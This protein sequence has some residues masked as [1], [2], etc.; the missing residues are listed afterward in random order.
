MIYLDLYLDLCGS[1]LIG[2]ACHSSC[3][4][5]ETNRENRHWGDDLID[6]P[7]KHADCWFQSWLSGLQTPRFLRWFHVGYIYLSNKVASFGFIEK[8]DG[9]PKGQFW[10]A[11][12]RRPCLLG[13]K[14]NTCDR[15]EPTCHLRANW[16][17]SGHFSANNSHCIDKMIVTMAL[18][19][20]LRQFNLLRSTPVMSESKPAPCSPRTAYP[21]IQHGLENPP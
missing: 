8:M 15:G 6:F 4:T 13:S 3:L 20:R 9:I 19:L 18:L 1:I 16:G 10:Y 7:L 11:L 12:C 17:P 5:L 21:R 2:K 14:K